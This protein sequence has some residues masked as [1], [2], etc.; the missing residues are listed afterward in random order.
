MPDIDPP[1]FRHLLGHFATGVTIITL[2]HADG[3]PTG[4][5]ASSLASASLQPPLVSVCIDRS[6][7]IHDLMLAAELWT[8]N[9]LSAEQ[10]ALSRRFAEASENRFDGVGYTTTR[11]GIVVLDGVL[12]H[13]ECEP[14]AHHDAGDHTLF[15]GRVVGGAARDGRPLLYYRG[16]YGPPL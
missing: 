11:R 12:A 2:V 7:E 16:G 6:A 1:E 10:E 3:R 4:M 5:T 14:E 9:I 8:V 13:L 15:L